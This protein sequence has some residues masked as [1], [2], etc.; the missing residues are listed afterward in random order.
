MS[1]A[2]YFVRH[3]QTAA[4]RFHRISGRVDLPLTDTGARQASLCNET[5][6]KLPKIDAIYCSPMSRTRHTATLALG[7]IPNLPEIIYDDRL[8][9]RD[10][11]SI[12]NKIAPFAQMRIWDYD[13]SYVRSHYGEE[14]LLH[15][16]NR[17][18]DFIEFIR[19]QHP[20]Q[21]VLVF[22]HGGVATAMHAILEPELDRT[23]NYFKHFHLQNGA[24]SSFTL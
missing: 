13:S 22:S 16:E 3:G 10:F 5:L 9:E 20:G 4:N 1:T 8:L 23:G 7:G 14:P 15:L 21:T 6:R 17:V 12:D 24:I 18:S 2:L 19:E 11:G